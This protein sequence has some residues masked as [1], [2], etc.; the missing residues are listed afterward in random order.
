MGSRPLHLRHSQMHRA[1][2]RDAG[3]VFQTREDLLFFLVLNFRL[4]TSVAAQQMREVTDVNNPSCDE[5][6]VKKVHRPL[7]A[8]SSHSKA[9]VS[10]TC[11]CIISR[12]YRD[13][14][15]KNAKHKNANQFSS[16]TLNMRGSIDP[17]P[18]ITGWG[19]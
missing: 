15:T 9:W 7:P 10:S 14:H 6:S 12:R 3:A 2:S 8:E 18:P 16:S 4:Q 11:C 13:Q 1:R 5:G 19:C 17:P